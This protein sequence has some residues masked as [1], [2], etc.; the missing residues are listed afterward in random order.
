MSFGFVVEKINIQLER[1]ANYYREFMH[2]TEQSFR[3]MHQRILH[4]EERQAWQEP[5]D[6]QVERVLRKI[7][8]ERFADA[9]VK[10]V[11]N[12]NV[13]KDG[14]YF[15]ENPDAHTMIP[16]SIPIDVD[17]LQVDP[18]AVPSQ[19]YLETMQ[20]LEGRIPS[21]PELDVWKTPGTDRARTGHGH[22]RKPTDN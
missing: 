13:M 17:S 18:G 20:M 4:L 8:A 1:L 2:R 14:D 5:S 9:G 21:F 22:D 11:R 19:R 15:V 10:G 6:E 12:P 16:E 7:L 3:A